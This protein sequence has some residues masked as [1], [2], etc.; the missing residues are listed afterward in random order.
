[1]RSDG[2]KQREKSPC[3]VKNAPMPEAVSCPQC[4]DTLKYGLTRKRQPAATA[5]KRS[6]AGP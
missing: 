1:M 4:A 6:I 3:S 5:G 2:Q